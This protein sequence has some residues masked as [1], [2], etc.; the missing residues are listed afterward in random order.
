DT[1]V[2]NRRIHT[3]THTH[4]H[5]H[6]HSHAILPALK[7]EKGGGPH[8]H[9]DTYLRTHFRLHTLYTPLFSTQKMSGQR[10]TSVYFDPC[11][12]KLFGRMINLIS[13]QVRTGVETEDQG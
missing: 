1:H 7:K 4:T 2:H 5:T 11:N 6:S 9:P 13:Q 8:A 12:K 10:Q 3:R